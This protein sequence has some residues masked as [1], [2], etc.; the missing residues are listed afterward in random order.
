MSWGYRVTI[1]TLGFVC[2]MLFLVFS[3]FQQTFDLVADDYYGKELKFEG[4]MAKQANQQHMKEPVL[5]TMSDSTLSIQFPTQLSG[6]TISGNILFFRPS[7]AKKDLL[8]PIHCSE[9]GV[10]EF[11][12]EQFS[13]GLYRIQIDYLAGNTTYY[14]EQ[15]IMI[16]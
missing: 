10:Q 11:L 12:I 14:S 6:K 4:Q 9:N 1:L 3:A 8:V 13:K 5:C 7:D 2:F 16:P 15:T